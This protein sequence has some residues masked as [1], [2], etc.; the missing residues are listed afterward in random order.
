MSDSRGHR[1]LEVWNRS[2]KYVKRIYQITREF[3]KEE[4]YGLV[5]QMRRSAIS[6]PSNIAEGSTRQSTKEYIRF[7]YIALG[8][9]SELE[10]QLILSRDLEYVTEEI[11]NELM[12][13]R[14]EISKMISGQIRSLKTKL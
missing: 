9:S 7:L 6:I 13:E 1:V 12:E 3:P 4:L 5:S 11:F 8:S 10:V 2:L 14:G